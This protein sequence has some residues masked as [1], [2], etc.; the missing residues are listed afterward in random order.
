MSIGCNVQIADLTNL[1]GFQEER[2][3]IAG[4]VAG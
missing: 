2:A 1:L 4:F 3:G